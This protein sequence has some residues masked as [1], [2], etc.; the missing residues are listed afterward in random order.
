MPKRGSWLSWLSSQTPQRQSEILASLDEAEAEMLMTCWDFTARTEQLEP[1]GDHQQWLICAGRGFGKTR[2][3]SEWVAKLAR[4]T[5]GIRIALVARSAADARMVMVSGESGILSV[6]SEDERPEYQPSK[7]Q[8]TWP[9]GSMAFTYSADEPGQL[10]GP[11]HHAAWCDEL[12]AWGGGWD[13]FDQLRL[14]LRLGTNPRLLVTTTPRPVKVI[15]DLIKDPK[16]VV[17][18]GSTYDNAANLAPTFLEQMQD[19]YEGTTLGRQE[20]HAEVMDELPGALWTRAMIEGQ[21]LREAPGHLLRIYVAVDPAITSHSKSDETGIV[22]VGSDSKRNFY[23]MG[24]H[25]GRYSPDEWAKLVV[26]LVEQYQADGVVA[27]VNQGGDMVSTLIRQVS[28]SV[29]VRQVR[30]SRSKVTRAEPVAARYEQGRVFHCGAFPLLEDQLCSYTGD[31]RESPDRLD[32]LVWGITQLETNRA[33]AIQM[34][35]GSNFVG[36]RWQ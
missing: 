31:S 36:D 32:A 7:R 18:R 5:P 28:P 33:P 13:A 10:R 26:K 22:V 25:S 11:Q 27:E 2:A 12:A 35:A 19:L 14:G 1:E 20:L 24:D 34:D 17:T 8:L 21:R 4:E 30:A 16:T 9:N 23:V 29:M 15:R 3:G 6:C